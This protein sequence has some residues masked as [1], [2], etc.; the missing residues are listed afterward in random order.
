MIGNW[1]SGWVGLDMIEMG[2]I[3]PYVRMVRCYNESITNVSCL[4]SSAS[5]IIPSIHPSIMDFHVQT[6]ETV[7]LVCTIHPSLISTNQSI[8][9]NR[10]INQPEN[11]VKHKITTLTIRQQLERLGI[12]HRLLFLIDLFINQQPI[13]PLKPINLPTTPR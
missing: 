11:I 6:K 12:A 4:L 2:D 8:S 7:I 13:S 3:E 9:L 5:S 1:R 10:R